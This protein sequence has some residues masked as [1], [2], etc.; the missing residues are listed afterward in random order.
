M[1]FPHLV[2]AAT[3]CMPRA[4]GCL[5]TQPIGQNVTFGESLDCRVQRSTAESETVFF[6]RRRWGAESYLFQ[7]RFVAPLTAWRRNSLRTGNLITERLALLERH[8][9]CLD[10]FI[11]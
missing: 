5:R 8:W 1:K 10:N 4:Q 6:K 2:D 9:W 3:F 7:P 11:Q